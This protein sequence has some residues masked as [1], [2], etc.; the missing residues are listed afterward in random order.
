MLDYYGNILL[1]SAKMRLV[2]DDFL[3]VRDHGLVMISCS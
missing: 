1:A 3:K 2:K